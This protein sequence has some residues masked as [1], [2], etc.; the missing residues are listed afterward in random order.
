MNTYNDNLHAQ[1][2]SILSE[3]EQQVNEAITS[4]KKA[5]LSL[6]HAQGS[7]VAANLQQAQAVK[8]YTTKGNALNEAMAN[9]YVSANILASAIQSK[10]H[11]DESVSAAATAAD[12]VQ[13]AANAITKLASDVGSTSSIAQAVDFDSDL[14][15]QAKECADLMSEVAHLA[16]AVS[17]D[18]M[19]ASALTA[20]VPAN[21]VEANA[22]QTNDSFKTLLASLN[23]EFD[24][25]KKLLETNADNL[26]KSRSADANEK[27]SF[28]NDYTSQNAAE[29]AYHL[30]NEKLNLDLRVKDLSSSGFTVCFNGIKS[31][32]ECYYILLVK[33]SKK[34]TF[35][36]ADAQHLI[37]HKGQYVEITP[38]KNDKNQSVSKAIQISDLRDADGDPMQLGE[39]YTVFILAVYADEY[40]QVL[41]S[42]DDFLSAPSAP[43]SLTYALQHPETA[44]ISIDEKTNT[45]AFSLTE[46]ADFKVSYRCM[47]LPCSAG[48]EDEPGFNFNLA[49]A[50][51]VQ[52]GNY[53]VA[54]VITQMLDNGKSLISGISRITESTTD[55]FGYPLIA[56]Q[57][58]L[59]VILSI[60]ADEEADAGQF[61]S[62]LTPFRSTQAFTF[63]PLQTEKH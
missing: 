10:T 26:D 21:T 20:E 62:S 53:T 31:P 3:Q 33:N 34:S 2:V 44:S 7:L 58:Y 1:V 19:E 17:Y 24:T 39:A 50:E 23:E 18:A 42:I 57:K 32:V 12:N 15:K 61:R 38:S 48:E 28:K 63:Q 56:G 51:Q 55:N 45:L 27:G 60:T 36:I 43:F 11:V 14:I 8:S 4:L 52:A 25:T 40:K 59:P 35:T 46:N 41:N 5:T 9:S 29:E 30:A 6:Y 16:E 13:L 47:Y 49:L 22:T 54:T 37:S